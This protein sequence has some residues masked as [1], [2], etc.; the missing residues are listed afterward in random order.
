[1]VLA[2]VVFAI[3][4]TPRL[5]AHFMVTRDL[6]NSPLALKLADFFASRAI[7][8]KTLGILIEWAG[9]PENRP[10]LNKF[11]ANMLQTEAVT[12][13]INQLFEMGKERI[14]AMFEGQLGA[15]RKELIGVFKNA[16][17]EEAKALLENKYVNT[18][19]HAV[20]MAG[21]IATMLKGETPR[22]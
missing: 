12:V 14:K 2:W 18:F 15:D 17:P 21:Q 7:N 10:I 22:E 19:I 3:Y 1:M 4:L 9:K 11:V 13:A 16:I 6:L 5:I 20:Q 8:E